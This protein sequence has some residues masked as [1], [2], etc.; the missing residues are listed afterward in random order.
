MQTGD[1]DGL[2]AE[3][4]YAAKQVQAGVADFLLIAT[5]TMHKM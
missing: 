2:L 5:N 1:W 3:L 4:I